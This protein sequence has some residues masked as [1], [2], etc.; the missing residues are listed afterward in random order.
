MTTSL[1]MKWIGLMTH[2]TTLSEENEEVSSWSKLSDLLD[3][4]HAFYLKRIER[5]WKRPAAW[6]P[7]G[8]AFHE[9]AEKLEKN[10]I[11]TEDGDIEKAFSEA[12]D[13]EVNKYAEDTP[14]FKEWF[15][16][17]P[18]G[19]EED[20]PR[21]YAIGLEQCERYVNWKGRND[22]SEALSLDEE[23]S[24]MVEYAFKVKFGDVTVQGVIDQVR[25]ER[26][27]DLKSG[28]KPGTPPQIA[29]Y[30]GALHILHGMPFTNGYFWMAKLKREPRVFIDLSEWSVQR[31]ADVYGD[32]REMVNAGHFPADPSPEKCMF[33]SVETSCIFSQKQR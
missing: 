32:A 29:T 30:A 21:R 11:G 10:L 17:G 28:N 12:Y 9:V 24:P 23:G 5:R 26:P 18:Y 27:V 16:S 20:I 4:P 8:T 31:L 14:N 19:G 33:C 22:P 15:S 6:L 25:R 13:R 1:M 2:T 7:Q 3:C